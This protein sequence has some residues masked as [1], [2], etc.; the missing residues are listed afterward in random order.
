MDVTLAEAIDLH[1]AGRLEEA[2]RAYAAILQVNPTEAGALHGLGVIAYQT[3]R[4]EAA[5][6]W[7]QRAVQIAPDT[8]LL[9]SNLTEAL[10]LL[11]RLPEA[12][13]AGRRAVT[14]GPEA[15]DSWNNLGMALLSARN[16]EEAMA[17]FRHAVSIRSDFAL[18]WNNLGIAANLLELPEAEHYFRRALQSRA[19]YD[20]ERS[21]CKP[22][23]AQP[24][25]DALNNLGMCFLARQQLDEAV[26]I[27]RRVLQV[28]SHHADACNNLGVAL[29]QQGYIK[30]GIERHRAAI[31]L[32]PRSASHHSN[33]LLALHCD[34]QMTAGALLQEH[35]Q[36][37][38]RHAEP[39][40][41]QAR[42]QP[43]NDRTPDRVLRIGYVSPRF[44]NS[45]ESRFLL[46][47]LASHDRRK[48]RLYCYSESRVADE[49]TGRIRQ[50]VDE[51]RNTAPMPDE[52]MADTIRRDGIDILVDLMVHGTQNRLLVFARKPAPIQITYL[53]YPGTTGMGALDYRFTDRYLDPDETP[54]C[55][56]EQSVR[57]ETYWCYPGIPDAPDVNRPPGLGA[58]YVTF[59]CLN[60]FQ[61]VSD[62]LI[63]YWRDLLAQVPHSRLMVHGADGSHRRR[64]EEVFRAA[65][66]EP[67]RLSWFPRVSWEEYLLLYGRMDVALDSHPYAGATT[68]CDAL[69]MGV[70]VV[71][72]AGATAV[73]RAGASLLNHAGLADLVARTPQDYVAIAAG[74]ARNTDRVSELRSNLRRQ[75]KDSILTDAPRHTRGIEAIYRKL[76]LEWCRR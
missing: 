50:C 20:D 46:P 51:W 21:E 59:G 11:N 58:G 32:N 7:M 74:L 57:L 54:E 62:V 43:A 38:E 76:W 9:W 61:K 53:A 65:G 31:A 5:V 39:L 72:L 3:G 35:R 27:Y 29:L 70:P 75:L 44:R 45:A 60:R 10:R 67:G 37:A 28:N 40:T 55:Y 68:T 18:A 6:D 16:V 71:T 26:A 41:R 15:A 14:L 22:D 64:V 34:P 66:I 47:L 24:L 1:T 19:D 4:L 48:F 63:G 23:R 2:E 13:A 17:C 33:L 8:A 30:E 49:F 42:P 12:I 25:L 69:W 56:S 73:A 36:W 52:V